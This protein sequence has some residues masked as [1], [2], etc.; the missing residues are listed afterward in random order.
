M[1]VKLPA[2]WPWGPGLRMKLSTVPFG[3]DEK[4]CRPIRTVDPCGRPVSAKRQDGGERDDK[5][6]HLD[7][8]IS[9]LCATAP[10]L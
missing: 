3:A 2:S 8:C 1:C 5:N 9:I 10:L 7:L 6:R 4:P